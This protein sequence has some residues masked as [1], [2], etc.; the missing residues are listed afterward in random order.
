[1]ASLS[2][3]RPAFQFWLYSGSI[4]TCTPGNSHPCREFRNISIPVSGFCLWLSWYPVWRFLFSF[5]L[6]FFCWR[7]P[8]EKLGSVGLIEVVQHLMPISCCGIIVS[9]SGGGQIFNTAAA[10]IQHSSVV[11]ADEDPLQL[12]LCWQFND[13]HSLFIWAINCRCQSLKDEVYIFWSAWSF[14]QARRRIRWVASA[15]AATQTCCLLLSLCA[16]ITERREVT[17]CMH[18]GWCYSCRRIGC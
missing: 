18:N 4:F 5:F 17:A 1:M 9:T 15:S 14:F 13:C 11:A 16:S 12:R 6:S 8:A 2:S 7:F 10:D 3:H